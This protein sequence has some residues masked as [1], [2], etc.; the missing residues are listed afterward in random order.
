[1]AM[2]GAGELEIT[3]DI[4]DLNMRV[5][6]KDSGS[7]IPN[8]IMNHIFEP[9]FTTKDVNEGTGLGLSMCR[10]I[11]NKYEGRIEV[12]SSPGEGSKFSILIPVKHLEN[13]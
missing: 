7:G 13:G 8:D 9:F 10:E 6:F 3:A 2:P 5:D 12:K 11:I 1:D 4:D